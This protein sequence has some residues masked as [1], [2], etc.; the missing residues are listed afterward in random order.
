MNSVSNKGGMEFEYAEMGYS[1]ANGYYIKIVINFWYNPAYQFHANESLKV[2]YKPRWQSGDAPYDTITPSNAD[3]WKAPGLGI[4]EIISGAISIITGTSPDPSTYHVEYTIK[5]LSPS[6]PYLVRPWLFLYKSNGDAIR[7]IKD[8]EL[9]PYIIW[10]T[11]Y[12]ETQPLFQVAQYEIS[13]DEVVGISWVDFT[14]CIKFDT[15]DVNYEDLNEDWDDANYVTH[16]IRARQRVT[17]KFEMI[18]PT[19][20]RYKIFLNLLEKS[21]Q[22][23]SNGPAYVQ[24]QVQIN[25]MLESRSSNYVDEQKCVLKMGYFFIKM[26]NNSWFQP[27][28]GHYNEYS[29]R[30]ITIQEA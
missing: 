7:G 27:K 24:L 4:A 11:D 14:D 15:Y 6:T 5:N 19:M 30:S 1:S 23:N 20:T 28:V 26:D 29:T 22:Y 12:T 25:N 21:R 10:T 3:V 9:S 13:N 8:P 18:F 2:Y 16:R 17:G